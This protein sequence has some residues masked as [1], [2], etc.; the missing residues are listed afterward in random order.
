MELDNIRPGDLLISLTPD[1]NRDQ[2]FKSGQA[3]G[4]S[5]SFFFFSKDNKFLIKTLQ[6]NEKRRLL[7]LLDNFIKHFSEHG[8]NS[9][10]ARIYGIFT[11]KSNKYAPIDLIIM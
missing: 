10:L 7:S 2:V 3:S 9:L 6:G 1:Q 8:E 5:G 4:A 11:F